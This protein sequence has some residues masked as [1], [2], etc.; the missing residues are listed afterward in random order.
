MLINHG[1]DLEQVYRS[2]SLTDTLKISFYYRPHTF[3]STACQTRKLVFTYPVY[4]MFPLQYDFTTCGGLLFVLTLCLILFGIFAG[5]FVPIGGIRV[6]QLSFQ[7]FSVAAPKE[8]RRL[9]FQSPRI[10]EFCCIFLFSSFNMFVIFLILKGLSH[11]IV[12]RPVICSSILL[13]LFAGLV[14]ELFI[15]FLPDN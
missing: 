12:N 3:Y 11:V 6:R 9:N 14:A 5:I 7:S 8:F 15:Q 4:A 2:Q 13:L 1:I 10:L